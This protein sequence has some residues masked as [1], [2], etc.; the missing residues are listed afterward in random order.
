M[1]SSSDTAPVMEK[2][3]AARA[4]PRLAGQTHKSRLANWDLA[5]PRVYFHDVAAFARRGR[6]RIIAGTAPR[7]SIHVRP[8][9]LS[10]P[11]GWIRAAA[12]PT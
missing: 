2:P 6:K 5:F 10:R 1:K 9:P 7:A 11:T 3:L 12:F 8:R 4:G